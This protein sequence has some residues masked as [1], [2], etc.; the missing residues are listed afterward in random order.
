M[1]EP[2]RMASKGGSLILPMKLPP[3]RLSNRLVASFIVAGVILWGAG[4][5][6]LVFYVQAETSRSNA[7]REL[8]NKCLGSGG[9]LVYDPIQKMACS[10]EAST[11][12]LDAK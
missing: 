12:T 5:I 6:A 11:Y 1:I 2:S 3:M 10:F 9:H 4:M 8:V 7:R